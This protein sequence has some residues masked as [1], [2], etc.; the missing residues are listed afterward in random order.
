MSETIMVGARITPREDLKI[1]KLVNDG[2]FIN[3]AD[4]VRTAIR[5][6][7]KIQKEES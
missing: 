1:L 3:K 5:S 7:L 2:R 4:F 6:E